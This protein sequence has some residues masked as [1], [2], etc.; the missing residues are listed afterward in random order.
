MLLACAIGVSKA[1]LSFKLYDAT[2]RTP[3]SHEI[4]GCTIRDASKNYLRAC[5]RTSTGN[6]N[7]IVRRSRTSI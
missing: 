2:A 7:Q 1:P 6:P 4:V 5:I 3:N